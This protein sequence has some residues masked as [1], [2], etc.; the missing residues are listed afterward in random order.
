MIRKDTFMGKWLLTLAVGMDPQLE[1]FL[2]PHPLS[3][4]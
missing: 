4:I 2:E 3:G 1:A